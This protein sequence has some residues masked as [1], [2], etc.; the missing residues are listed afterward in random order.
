MADVHL[1]QPPCE[2][3]LIGDGIGFR[4]QHH[5]PRD[6]KP[7]R[8]AVHAKRTHEVG[9]DS[10][11]HARPGIPIASSVADGNRH[12][13]ERTVRNVLA[14]VAIAVDP[15]HR[16]GCADVVWS[17]IE[18]S[19]VDV[20]GHA[21]VDDVAGIY[22]CGRHR[23]PECAPPRAEHA[24]AH[25]ESLGPCVRQRGDLRALQRH[26][27]IDEHRVR[28]CERLVERG[29]VPRVKVS[30]HFGAVGSKFAYDFRRPG[31][32]RDM[33]AREIRRA[34]TQAPQ[35][36]VKSRRLTDVLQADMLARRSPVVLL[37]VD[38]NH[39]RDRWQHR[40]VQQA[41]SS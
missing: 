13:D 16:H 23:W 30:G 12:F 38:R 40:G 20:R 17:I 28:R 15:V 6:T 34:H 4:A 27:Q 18:T 7:R 26:R 2:R 33:V 32:C 10:A 22:Q 19:P 39:E 37:R 1:D 11:I 36:H 29:R 35:K 41:S 25:A 9:V 21:A 8:E 14:R 5:P 3:N 31:A 24:R